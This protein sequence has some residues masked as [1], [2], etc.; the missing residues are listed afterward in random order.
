[1]S[2]TNTAFEGITASQDYS[3][4]YGPNS[5]V[6]KTYVDDLIAG[7]DLSAYVPYTGATATVE[8]GAQNLRSAKIFSTES[9]T[10]TVDIRSTGANSGGLFR[11]GNDESI[12]AYDDLSETFNFA[13]DRWTMDR[14]NG[15]STIYSD[16]INLQTTSRGLLNLDV[17][18]LTYRNESDETVDNFGATQ[19][20]LNPESGGFNLF[21]Q[22]YDVAGVVE[23]ET[24]I[25]GD[26]SELTM[27]AKDMDADFG[28]ELKLNTEGVF[29]GGGSSSAISNRGYFNIN[30]S[31]EIVT[32]GDF[33][34]NT[35]GTKVVVD[36]PNDT[37]DLDANSVTVNS[38]RVL[39]V[40]D[41]LIK[42]VTSDVTSR[43]VI[44]TTAETVAHSY[45]ITGSSFTSPAFLDLN[46]RL[47]KS[48]TAGASTFRLYLNT[49]S[50]TTAGGVLI[51]Q[52]ASSAPTTG[53]GR[54]TRVFEINSSNAMAGFPPTVSSITD[55][56]AITASVL[57]TTYTPTTTYYL[58]ATFQNQSSA[59]TAI[60]NSFRVT[61]SK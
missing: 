27:Y 8:L 42:T 34:N 7:V 47:S 29:I 45:E 33:S 44:G 59:D 13:G 53:V 26:Q 36:I 52:Y 17:D 38:S 51:G 31:D 43:S 60:I 11:S 57:S 46:C 61:A 58:V 54:F 18:G 16:A 22:E 3:A 4:N 24:Y 21:N 50:G 20:E 40:A 55:L 35:N 39:T 5:Y 6:Q 15:V 10:E 19:F 49:T 9:G 23:F 37:I 1:L 56:I 12:S 48:G 25:K 32:T 30:L 2:S 41:P 14:A 28:G